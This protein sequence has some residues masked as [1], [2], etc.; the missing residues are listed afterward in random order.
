MAAAV[1]ARA[2]S[3]PRWRAP[4]RPAST[5][6]QTGLAKPTERRP[7]RRPRVEGTPGGGSST[8]SGRPERP[9]SD[10]RPE[11]RPRV[12]GGPA[13]ETGPSSGAGEQRR[14][15]PPAAA[16]ARPRTPTRPVRPRPRGC[17]SAGGCPFFCAECTEE[18][19]PALRAWHG[20][21]RGVARRLG[22][23]AAADRR[24]PRRRRH[25]SSAPGHCRGGERAAQRAGRRYPARPS[26]L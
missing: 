12:E 22:A 14:A 9:A 8:A 13:G 1:L 15:R 7:E 17:P 25:T 18:V 4:R 6:Q 2:A 16:G 3:R 21:S 19:S 26:S 23:R 20:A 11:R 10:R 5:D 24:T